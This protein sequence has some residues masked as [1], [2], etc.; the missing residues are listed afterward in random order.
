[1]TNTDLATLAA[2]AAQ[3]PL[4]HADPLARQVAA[5]QAA[6]R[7]GCAYYIADRTDARDEYSLPT[8]QLPVGPHKRFE[9]DGSIVEVKAD[10]TEKPARP[11]FLA[12]IGDDLANEARMSDW[13]QS[14]N[15][16]TTW[17]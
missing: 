15:R 2:A 9:V 5:V 13:A 16:G 10:G 7:G 3:L 6:V 14:P 8:A 1:M 4:D 11:R 12:A 17:A